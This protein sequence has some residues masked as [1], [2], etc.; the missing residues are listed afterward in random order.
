M[1]LRSLPIDVNT[2]MADIQVSGLNRSDYRMHIDFQRKSSGRSEDVGYNGRDVS[3]LG[4]TD[5]RES[6]VL[7]R[8]WCD[9]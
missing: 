6:M 5:R 7:K 4:Q 8:E 3:R 9:G 2:D 1:D